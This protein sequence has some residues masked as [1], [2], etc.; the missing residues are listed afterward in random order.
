[1]LPKIVNG[2]NKL[3]YFFNYQRNYDDSAARNTPT[4][5]VPANAKHLD[6]DFS[7]LLTLGT[8]GQYQ[9][10]DPLTVRPDPARPG[11]FIR[12]P[13]PNNIIPR[14]RFMNANGTYKNPLFALYKDMIPAPNQNFVEQGQIPTGNYYQGGVPNLTN[15]SNFG[16]RI[17][18]NASQSDRF[19][20]RYAGHD[21]PRAARRLDVR[22]AEPEVPR[23]AR[24]RQDALFVGVHRQLDESPGV[25][26]R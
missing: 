23:A 18:Y 4:S 22:I 3:F 7:D 19:F 11:S 13:F 12:T 24:Q 16:G 20:F 25:D 9:I 15:A 6:G 10:Y 8:P 1:M 21:V 2:R 14:D 5:T 17:D 26:G